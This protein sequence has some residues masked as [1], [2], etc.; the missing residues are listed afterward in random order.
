MTVYN[1]PPLTLPDQVTH[2]MSRGLTI[3]DQTHA[4]HVLAQVGLYRLKGFLL[5]YKTPSGYVTGTIFADA[6]RLMALDEQLRLHVLKA[7]QRVEVGLRQTISQ[8][9][10]ERYGVRWYAEPLRFKPQDRYFQHTEFL[11]KA[12][13]EFH[14]M[15]ELFVG[16]YRKTYDPRPYPPAWMIAETMSLGSWSKLFNAI[17]RPSDRDAITVPLGIRASTVAAWLHDL[18]VVRNVCAHHA[19]LYDRTFKPAAV[20]DNKRLRRAL[21]AKSFDPGDPRSLRLAP[22]L[23]ALHRLTRALDAT[24]PWTAELK[25]MLGQYTAAELPRLGLQPNWDTQPEWI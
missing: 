14:K 8:Y 5:P 23:Y 6:E 3:P 24:S 16:H 7:M 1:R 10:L 12:V 11:A 17:D 15:P 21:L 18:T 13:H 25:M 4:Q 20:A 9:M 19:R 22:R 2:L